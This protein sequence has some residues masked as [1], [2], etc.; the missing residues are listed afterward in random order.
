MQYL[1]RKLEELLAAIFDVFENEADETI[2]GRD[3]D[4]ELFT[5]VDANN[6]S[7]HAYIGP[8]W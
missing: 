2:T 6:N 3:D 5:R 4:E 7:Y 8:C 1:R